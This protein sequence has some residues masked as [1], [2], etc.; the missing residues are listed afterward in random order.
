MRCI[1][2]LVAQESG[3]R[4]KPM[5][6]DRTE[7]ADRLLGKYP[8]GCSDYVLVLIDN[9]DVEDESCISTAPLLTVSCFCS[10]FCSNA[11]ITAAQVDPISVPSVG[12]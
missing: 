12:G 1:F 10:E 5:E 2:Q 9:F 6:A 8:S 11:A 3:Y 7:F 4:S